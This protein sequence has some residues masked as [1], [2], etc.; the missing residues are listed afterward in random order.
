[1]NS[2]SPWDFMSVDSVYHAYGG[3][4]DMVLKT[5][6]VMLGDRASN[7]SEARGAIMF[8]IKDAK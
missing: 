8:V 4:T 6:C 5:Y 7:I 3:L 2:L 1:M